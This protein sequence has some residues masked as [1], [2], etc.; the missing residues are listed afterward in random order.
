[1]CRPLALARAIRYCASLACV[2]PLWACSSLGTLE[3]GGS[4]YERQAAALRAYDKGEDAQAES[5]YLGL[6]RLSPNDAETHF[7][8]G[9]LYA[10]SGRPDRAAES[11][12]QTLMASPSDVRAW[13]NLGIVRQRQAQAALIA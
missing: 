3:L 4:P 2:L 12:M 11:Y 13:Y 6:L 1:M 9:N 5:L 8:L 10:R 7:R